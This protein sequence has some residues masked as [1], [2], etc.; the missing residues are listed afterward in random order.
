MISTTIYGIVPPPSNWKSESINKY[1]KK[2][3]DRCLNLSPDSII[4]YDIQ[5]EK[6][7]N[8]K[9]R[10]FPFHLPYNPLKF[11]EILSSHLLHSNIEIIL[12]QTLT[13]DKPLDNL[14]EYINECHDKY[15]IKNL[16]WVGYSK[17][18]TVS[19]ATKLTKQL[20]PNINI[21]GVTIPER[22]RDR[23]DEDQRV[24]DKICAGVDFFTSQ[25]IY[26][27]DNMITFLKDYHTLC[28]TNNIKPKM[29]IL[30]FAPFGR[31]ETLDFMKWLGV[32]IPP[33][34]ANRILSRKTIEECLEE[35]IEI[36]CEIYQTIVNNCQKN[37]LNISLGITVESV[38]KYRD[39]QKAADKLFIFLKNFKP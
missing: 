5:D 27:V 13:S 35:S 36:C 12:Y 19:D 3:A 15:D 21:G 4:I 14:T 28:Q 39:E 32:E 25:I 24:V 30:A 20:H 31:Q 33:G 2:I 34:T 9:Q 10:P 1:A 17:T 7:R 37:N 23:H 29:I 16:V 11:S 26:N 22:H 6:G 38:S 8:G 18:F